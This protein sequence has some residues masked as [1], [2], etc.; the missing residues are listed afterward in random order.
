[1]SKQYKARKKKKQRENKKG[2]QSKRYV[3]ETLKSRK[4]YHFAGEFGK[5][6]HVLD[7]GCGPGFGSEILSRYA[8]KVIAV[9]IRTKAINY[10]KS[11]Y[12]KPNLSF[13]IISSSKPLPFEDNYFDVIISSH[14]IEH[15]PNV[16]S[17]LNELNRILKV[18][19]VLIL[20]TPNRKFRLL[21]FQKPYN[22]YHLRE[23]TPKSFKKEIKKIFQKVSIKGVYG[24]KEITIIE[25][26]RKKALKNPLKVYIYSPITFI[27][28]KILPIKY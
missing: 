11:K 25:N 8:K 28:R 5:A 4:E 17:Y 3:I 22:P 23:Y 10:A 24:T 27:L 13:Q 18:N 1:M 2:I 20:S 16:S 14:V 15:I 9:D 7:Y 26:K 21:P 12:I 6:K 19:G